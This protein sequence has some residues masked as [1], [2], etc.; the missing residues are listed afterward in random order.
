MCAEQTEVLVLEMKHYERLFVK[1]H[2]RTIE[3]MRHNLE[4]KLN[5]RTSVLSAKEN[6][7]IPL[8][9]LIHLKLYFL[10]NPPP[11]SMEKKKK[12]TSVQS[13][14]KLFFNHK[15]PLLDLYGPGSVF[16]LIRIREQSKQKLRAHQKEGLKSKKQEM[17]HLHA[18]RL[19]Q[20]LVMAAQIAGAKE[21]KD[22]VGDSIP[23]KETEPAERENIRQRTEHITR[24][25]AS[26][27]TT[28]T[29]KNIISPRSFRC[30]QSAITPKQPTDEKFDNL[31]RHSQ[32]FSEHK[33]L[34]LSRPL[35]D[36]ELRL[37]LLEEKVKDWLERDNPKFGTNVSK[38]RRL[39][40]E[41]YFIL[42]ALR[43]MISSV[44]NS[45]IILSS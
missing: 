15:G 39:H 25:T 23:V 10:H 29:Q 2:Q 22:N 41:V 40:V 6:A 24:T 33:P 36:Q 19:P 1:R 20:N 37:G 32:Y 7:D 21:T 43:I 27:V 26:K 14:E 42:C 3:Q 9:G 16:Y 28:F 5:T 31:T 35:G 17:G 30:I 8:L 45:S 4:H 18:I 38:L 44:H 12:E 11:V 13:A 34:P